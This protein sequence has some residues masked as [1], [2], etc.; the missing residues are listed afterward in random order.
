MEFFATTG[1]GVED[2]LAEELRALGVQLQRLKAV[3]S[4][5]PETL[6]IHGGPTFGCG[7]PTVY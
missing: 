6:P 3:A 7:Q 2:V 5:L 1:K 4:V